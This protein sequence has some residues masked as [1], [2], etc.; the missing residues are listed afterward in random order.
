MTRPSPWPEIDSQ[1]REACRAPGIAL[2]A[3]LTSLS[4]GSGSAGGAAHPDRG[5]VGD[6]QGR[7]QVAD[8]FRVDRHAGLGAGIERNAD[9]G[10]HPAGQFGRWDHDV[11]HGRERRHRVPAEPDGQPPGRGERGHELGAQVGDGRQEHRG[12]VGDRAGFG[13]RK[14]EPSSAKLVEQVRYLVGIL[15]RGGQSVL[16]GDRRGGVDRRLA[17]PAGVAPGH[18]PRPHEGGAL[19]HGGRLTRRV[20]G[21]CSLSSSSSEWGHPAASA[22]AAAGVGQQ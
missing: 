5:A 14:P 15:G 3:F 10:R 21:R 4:S 12:P 20:H 8:A 11:R 16:D 2:S 22:T 7:G 1:A 6:H 13:Q 17:G 18:G 9:A 19:R